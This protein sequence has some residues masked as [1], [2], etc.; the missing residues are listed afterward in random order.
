MLAEQHPATL[1]VVTGVVM[2]ETKSDVD[3]S[4]QAIVIGR[5]RSL[6]LVA[7]GYTHAELGECMAESMGLLLEHHYVRGNLVRFATRNGFVVHSHPVLFAE[8]PR[9]PVNG[10]SHV[11]EPALA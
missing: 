2:W 5:C 3:D 9:I 7:W 1:P 8:A 10:T 6:K 4:G 11:L